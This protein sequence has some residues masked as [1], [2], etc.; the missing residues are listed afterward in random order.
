V[1]VRVA[2]GKGKRG[3]LAACCYRAGHDVAV[4]PDS[5]HNHNHDNHTTTITTE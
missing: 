4:D 3:E 5:I 2:H 1:E